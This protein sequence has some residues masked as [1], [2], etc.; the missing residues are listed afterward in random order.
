MGPNHEEQ[1]VCY[2]QMHSTVAEVRRPADAGELALIFAEAR[3]GGRRITMR[4]GGNA[5]DSQSLGSDL[6]ISL[7]RLDAI[8]DVFD[9]NGD[10]CITVGAG[11]TWGN[12]LA[13]VE[14]LGLVPAIMVTTEKATAGG[15]LSGNCLSRFSPTLGKEGGW[16][17]R[18]ELLT[19]GGERLACTPPGDDGRPETWTLAERA[20]MSAIGG[21]G[22]VGA[23]VEITYKLVRAC[24]PSP[25]ATLAVR[26]TLTKHKTYEHLAE[27]LVRE[28]HRMC[29][30]EIP[31]GTS[32]AEHDETQAIY[33]GLIRRLSG[34][35]S[36]LV[37]TSTYTTDPERRP[38]AIHQPASRA[39]FISELLLR[40]PIDWLL[41]L[42]GYHVLNRE[43]K[44][45]ID[46]LRGFT[47][48]MDGNARC[49]AWGKRHGLKMPTVQQTFVVPFDPD[50]KFDSAAAAEAASCVKL[51]AWLDESY[52]LL[53]AQKVRPTFSDVL[54]VR[55]AK[56]FAL[57]SNAGKAGFAVS[58]AFETN[59]SRKLARIER[60]FAM[61]A[62]RL[63][64]ERFDGRVYLVKNV[65]A[66]QAVLRAMYGERAIGFLKLK[67]RLDPD[68]LLA[69]EFFER[70]FGD[71]ADEV[72]AGAH[73]D[74]SAA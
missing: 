24:D 11:A 12:I 45:Y 1:L 46:D 13:K 35:Q 56:P 10:D 70:T 67:R 58:H 60:A 3:A 2:S 66:S 31:T 34:K 72:Y 74:D 48:F 36:A 54:F 30:S 62:E 33:S 73:G 52:A 40:T 61:L 7:E 53:R 32:L 37:M 68:R 29:D 27:R 15:T 41:S 57:S 21:L 9:D 38:M 39:R 71:L 14:P 43:G 17:K 5:F 22:Y 63:A 20:F 26:T 49:K 51:A 23:V 28:A 18:F 42:F 6:V 47:F 59:S 4:A 50:E 16:V 19:V 25:G 8:G 65:Y 69:N 64:D 55:D 44:V